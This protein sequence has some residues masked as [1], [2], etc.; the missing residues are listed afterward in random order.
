MSLLRVKSRCEQGGI[1]FWRLCEELFPASRGCPHCSV[2][3][4]LQYS[5]LE[6]PMDRGACQA[7]VHGVTR[8]GHNLATKPQPQ[9]CLN[10]LL[11]FHPQ[12]QQWL[13]SFSHSAVSLVLILL[14]LSPLFKDQCDYSGSPWRNPATLERNPAL[15]KVSWLATLIAPSLC[16]ITS[17]GSRD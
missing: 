9:G 7:T 8:V 15:S 1:P 10:C 3:N 6:N 14:H 13:F 11:S 5:C 17:V 4:P 16:N 2:C 12:S